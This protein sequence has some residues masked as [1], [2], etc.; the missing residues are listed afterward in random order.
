MKILYITN[1]KTIQQ[2][3]GYV[4]DY[5]ND[6]V[7]HGLHDLLGEG[8]I[9]ELVDSTPIEHLYKENAKGFDTN[10][11]W[12]LGFSSS[13][14]IEGDGSSVNRA[15]IPLKI[16]DRYFDRVI[17][18]SCTRCLEYYDIVSKY[19]ENRSVVMLDGEDHTV[20]SSH[21]LQ[22]PYFK[23]ELL[24]ENV[25]E[26]IRP[27]SFGMPL[28]KFM[29][30][31][32]NKNLDYATIVPGIPGTYVYDNEADYY[33]GYSNS[34]YGMTMKKSGWD[35]MRHYEILAS[36]S[37]PF[38]LMLSECPETILANF[39]KDLVLRGMELVS[40][41]SSEDYYSIMDELYAYA[42]EKLT[43]KAVANYVLES[44]L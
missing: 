37:M 20:L 18:G 11:L 19:Y 3:G 21:L 2:A 41:F 7:F 32:K 22:H 16:K 8:R 43:T 29:L 6:L 33:T 38:F 44:V 24:P 30:P 15:D 10:V 9:S 40:N 1:H 34:Y 12:G 25:T 39:P 14:L 4:N 26:N 23:R 35:C 27:I 5:L 28:C 17:Y 13:F 42:Q 31:N 36:Y